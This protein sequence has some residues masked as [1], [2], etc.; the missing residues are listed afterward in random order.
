[1]K[2]RSVLPAVLLA[3]PWPSA[4]DPVQDPN[5]PARG[6][7]QVAPVPIERESDQQSLEDVFR[8][9]FRRD[10]WRA[11]LAVPDLDERLH[12]FGQLVDRA[13]IDPLAR[14]F[15]EE[16]ARDAET[17]LAWTAR[18]ALRELGAPTF[19]GLPIGP[20]AEAFQD[21]FSA[22][23]E[24]LLQERPELHFML[25]PSNGRARVAPGPTALGE[26]RVRLVQRASE[27]RVEVTEPGADGQPRTEVHVGADLASV[28]AA[29]PEL[30]DA[31]RITV[32]APPAALDLT[33]TVP[34]R[35]GAEALLDPF[36][37]GA[38]RGVGEPAQD[39]FGW[40]EEKDGKLDPYFSPS[41][42]VEVR[43]D[44]LGVYV[45]PITRERA[46]RLGVEHGL[47]VLQ[48]ER[49]TIAD[50]MGVRVDDVLVLL[51]GVALHEP[52]SITGVMDS[53][54]RDQP[55]SLVWI[56]DIGERVQS[57]WTPSPETPPSPGGG[58]DDR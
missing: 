6:L 3:L 15:V 10:E 41:G 17:G 22:L 24:A 2:L 37:Y 20:D 16:L 38:R 42:V 32:A 49:G 51:N 12:G 46:A 21:R 8:R 26:L 39:P 30:A 53:R 27:A 56:D 5:A 28:L 54:R 29:L 14:A 35:G 55:V 57:T 4:Q 48:L 43:A 40:L 9:E 7:Q 33:L 18:L 45:E 11:R 25:P 13:R 47:R 50:A 52:Q 19:G 31:L 36:A 1:M 34:A 44:V 23:F 58:A